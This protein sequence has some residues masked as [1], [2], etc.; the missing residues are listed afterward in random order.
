MET[1]L[2]PLFEVLNLNSDLL[3]NCLD[4]LSEVDALK[5]PESEIN[6]IAFLLVHMVDA[7]HFMAGLLGKP[8]D[9]PLSASLVEV[10]SI[11]DAKTLPG[12]ED[13]RAQWQT[14]SEH[15]ADCF[16]AANAE[17]LDAISS[18]KFPVDDPSVLAGL[19]FLLQHDSYHLGQVALL[20]RQWGYSAMSYERG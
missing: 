15:L 11:E 6:N 13:L 18:Q 19:A 17:E 16:R 5:Q 2:Y 9:N 20:R 14:V 1:A 8:L 3:L 7:R 12:L 10:N 4:E